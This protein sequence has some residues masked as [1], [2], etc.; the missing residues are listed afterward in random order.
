MG[1]EAPGASE[2]LIPSFTWA[3][4]SAAERVAGFSVLFFHFSFSSRVAQNKVT[5][6]V[7]CKG[8]NLATK[9]P[10]FKLLLDLVRIVP[11]LLTSRHVQGIVSGTSR[12]L[13]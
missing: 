1:H 6:A 2:V 5:G 7:R 8:I 12:N 13:I 3:P 9:K 4:T 10:V 11:T